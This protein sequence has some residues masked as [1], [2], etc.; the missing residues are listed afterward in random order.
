[1]SQLDGQLELKVSD[2]LKVGY[3]ARYDEAEREFIDSS[4]GVRILSSCNCWHLDVGYTER[5]NPEKEQVF[6]RFTF[7]G[8]GD[9]TQDIGMGSGTQRGR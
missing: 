3:Y 6:M 9:I 1:M 5:L 2:R 7:A 8:L 4:V